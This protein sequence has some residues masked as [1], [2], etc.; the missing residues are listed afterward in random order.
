[1]TT[2]APPFEGHILHMNWDNTGGW[3]SQ[4]CVKNS[5]AGLAV[6]GCNAGTWG[7]WATM[8]TQTYV[9]EAVAS[10]STSSGSYST[11]G[12]KAK[13]GT[14]EI[15]V[16][17]TATKCTMSGTSFT[18]GSNLSVS[19]G[20]VN[21]A[22][23]GTVVVSGMIEY[24]NAKNGTTVPTRLGAGIWCDSDEMCRSQFILPT[25]MSTS[26]TIGVSTGT[27]LIKITSANSKIYLY[28][29]ADNAGDTKMKPSNSRLSVYYI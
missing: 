25:S 7:N 22:V 5:S 26:Q 6:R 10:V 2:G 18:V 28:G 9:D 16:N 12:I 27:V 3:D 24:T 11:R 4:L 17:S 13:G 14:T 15:S 20:G 21:C 1:M 8:A 23:T 29:Y 19:N